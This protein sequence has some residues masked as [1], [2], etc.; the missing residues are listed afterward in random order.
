LRVDRRTKDLC[1][2]LRP[3]EIAVIDHPDLDGTAAQALIDCAPAA[4]VNAAQSITGRYPNHGPTLLLEAG[5]P[6]IDACGPDLLAQ[7]REGQTAELRGGALW[8]EGQKVATGEPVTPEYL[9]RFLVA[10]RENL[11]AELEAF[12]QNTLEYL[13]REKDQAVADFPL[14]P[15][16]TSFRNRPVLVVVRG[17]GY[18]RDLQWVRPF[19]RERR[20][21]LLAVDGGADALLQAGHKPDLIVG[22]MDSATEAALRCGA[23]L[24]VHTYTDGRPSPGLERLQKLGLD[25]QALAVPGTSEDVA[26]LMAHQ[27]GAT[28]IVAV[29]T[30][31]SLV[32]FLDKRRSGMASTLITRLKVGSILV[33]AKGLSQLYR[34]DLSPALVISLF[35]SAMLPVIVVLVNSAP[36]QRWLGL[37]RMGVDVW[38]RRH[39]LRW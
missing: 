20:P 36:M 25:A 16:R 37:L 6:L 27:G 23:E 13:A 17:E 24:V 21:V 26:M 18:K 12:T 35:V 11:G 39:G 15:L 30:H 9:E 19:I 33:D 4:V 3:G 5:I 32:E 8:V 7:V 22:D 38:L 2:R 31:F 34:P 14:P 1:R 10:A 28:L 29:G